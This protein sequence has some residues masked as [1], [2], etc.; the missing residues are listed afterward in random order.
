MPCKMHLSGATSFYNL[1]DYQLS[2]KPDL[3]S[4]KRRFYRIKSSD[5]K[6]ILSSAR[7]LAHLKNRGE[8]AV[9]FT[10]T[11]QGHY[12]SQTKESSFNGAYNPYY[13][14]QISKFLNKW[15]SRG[16]MSTFLQGYI[17]TKELT[18]SNII[19]YHVIGLVDRKLPAGIVLKLN[20]V[21]GSFTKQNT[22]NGFRVGKKGIILK[23]VMHSVLYA[24]KYAGKSQKGCENFPSPAF[25]I[26]NS[27][28]IDPIKFLEIENDYDIEYIHSYFNEIYHGEWAIV[29]QTDKKVVEK[30]FL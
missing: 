8:T 1:S 9:F 5:R 24:S 26:S 11:F 25:R 22:K 15:T 28:K 6:N 12:N 10:L 14:D 21:W 18:D 2:A 30:Y 7:L 4:S 27:L 3:K 19:H 17:W 29:G 20:N 13:N 16:I 23:N